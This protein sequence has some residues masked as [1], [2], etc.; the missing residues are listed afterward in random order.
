MKI[1]AINCDKGHFLVQKNRTKSVSNSQIVFTQQNDEFSTKKSSENKSLIL[2]IGLGAIAL[3][4][5]GI[6]IKKGLKTSKPIKLSAIEQEMKAFPQDIEYRKKILKDLNLNENE[7]SKLR[8]VI[9]IQEFENVIDTL[10]KDIEHFMPGIK[11]H[12]AD[13]EAK[14]TGL[15]NVKNGKFA[16]NL[17]LHTKYSDGKFEIADLMEQAAAYADKRV[18]LLGENNPFY[19]AI[20]DHNTAKGCKEA[21]SIILENPE[22]YKNLRL[23][24]GVE[25]T[26]MTFYEGT[27][28]GPVQTHMLSYCINPFDKNFDAYMNRP[29]EKNKANIKKALDN[30]NRNYENILKPRGVTYNLDEMIKMVPA[31]NES[32]LSASYWA[33]DYMQFKLIYKTAVENNKSLMEFLN[34]KGVQH[35]FTMPITKIPKNPDYSNGQK[36]YEYYFEAIKTDLKS[37]LSAEDAKI[38][39]SKL[40]DFPEDIRNILNKIEWKIS[41]PNSSLK[42]PDVEYES[43]ENIIKFMK[44]QEYG[45]LGIA[46]PGVVFPHK[47]LI[48]NNKT[49]EFYQKLFADFK[50]WGGD[51]AVFAENNY[52]VYFDDSIQ[53]ILPK[54]TKICESYG[55]K[56]TGGLDTHVSD[57]FKSK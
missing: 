5:A 51:K 55:L 21:V 11:T 10:S 56:K 45:K 6:A 54:L 46:H 44:T 53:E 49:V 47:N 31:I 12:G 16:A 3:L 43:L 8:S 18:A 57:I 19:L 7:Y 4:G 28:H 14:F 30:A 52:A 32:P 17:H 27:L 39:D 37:K 15:E 36:Y 35:D 22:K 9:G 2:K 26:G 23:V 29:V 48:D 13:H 33:K 34:S 1:S 40:K 42:I 20:T 38:L 24:L 41:D 25:H 50:K